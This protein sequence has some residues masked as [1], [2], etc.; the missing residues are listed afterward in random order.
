[1]Q[2]FLLTVGSVL[3]LLEMLGIELR[4]FIP[5]DAKTAKN[6]KCAKSKDHTNNNFGMSQSLPKR[7]GTGGN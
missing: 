6:A 3:G 2:P 5:F 7:D 4:P 1:V